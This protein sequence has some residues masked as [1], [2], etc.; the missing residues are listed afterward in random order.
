MPIIND[1][2]H[3]RTG[4]SFFLKLNILIQYYTFK[5]DNE[6]KDLCTIFTPFG[7]FKYNRL[8]MGLKCSPDIAHKVMENTLWDLDDTEVYINDVG[9]FSNSWS[10]YMQFLD[11][12]LHQM[13]DNGFTINPLK[14]KWASKR[15]IGLGI[16]LLP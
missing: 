10:H 12:V 13:Q 8:P 7:K 14:C 4:Y 6:H 11:E 9:C 1:I 3:K 5:F 2:L 16:G 15:Q